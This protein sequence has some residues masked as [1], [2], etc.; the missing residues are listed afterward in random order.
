VPAAEGGGT[1]LRLHLALRLRKT[2]AEIREEEGKGWR[3]ELALWSRWW[4]ATD[5]AV[6]DM[7]AVGGSCDL[8]PLLAEKDNEK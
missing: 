5:I 6:A 3:W 1:I 4:R 7:V 2:E 8:W